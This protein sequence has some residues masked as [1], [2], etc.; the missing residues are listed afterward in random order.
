MNCNNQEGR[1]RSDRGKISQES[2]TEFP[3][4]EVNFQPPDEV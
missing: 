2:P 1:G 3:L 4:L